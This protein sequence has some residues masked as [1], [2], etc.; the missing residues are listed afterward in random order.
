MVAQLEI[1][2]LILFHNLI[3]PW[4]QVITNGI[5]GEGCVLFP[6][7]FLKKEMFGLHSSVLL[8][9]DWNVDVMVSQLWPCR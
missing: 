6:H 7:N 9:V 3:W 4:D 5:H 1:H 8:S 2:P